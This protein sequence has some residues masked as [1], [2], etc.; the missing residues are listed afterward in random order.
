VLVVTD[1][2]CSQPLYVAASGWDEVRRCPMRAQWRTAVGLLCT[3]HRDYLYAQGVLGDDRGVFIG[4]TI[5]TLP[6]L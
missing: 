1:E 4:R 2:L 3:K 5:E 6:P